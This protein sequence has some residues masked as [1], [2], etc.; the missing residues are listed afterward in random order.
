[1]QQ[2]MNTAGKELMKI[3]LTFSSWMIWK[4]NVSNH[5]QNLSVSTMIQHSGREKL[6][7]SRVRMLKWDENIC[8]EEWEVTDR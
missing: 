2:T 4:R 1:M 8:T 7:K 5:L 3:T 6:N